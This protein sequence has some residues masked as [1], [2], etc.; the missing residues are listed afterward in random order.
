[1]LLLVRELVEH[2][3]CIHFCLA[4]DW[5]LISTLSIGR[6]LVIIVIV[7]VVIVLV[8]IVVVIVIVDVIIVID[9]TAVFAV[10][11]VAVDWLCL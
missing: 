7:N 4:I 2:A 10:G 3:A 8:I 5:L 11:F 9:V 6:F 1:M